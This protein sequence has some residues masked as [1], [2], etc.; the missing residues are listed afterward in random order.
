MPGILDLVGAGRTALAS[1]GE[2]VTF[3]GASLR[4]PPI[5]RSPDQRTRKTW[6]F[7][8]NVKSILDLPASLDP[9]PSP[10]LSDLATDQFGRVHR[11]VA[12][13]FNGVSFICGCT[14]SKP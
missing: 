11:I 3:R 14:V 12:V 7:G 5:V 2:D 4:I 13:H 1:V 8:E 6:N 9:A 10:E